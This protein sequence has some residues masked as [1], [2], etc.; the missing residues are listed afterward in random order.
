MQRGIEKGVGLVCDQL[1]KLTTPIRSEDDVA[2]IATI[3]A[4]NDEKIGNLI[5]KAVDSV[6]KDGSI[7]VEPA[8]SVQTSLDLV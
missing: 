1:D 2:H 5:A 4:N 6:V 8:H 7:T 3:S